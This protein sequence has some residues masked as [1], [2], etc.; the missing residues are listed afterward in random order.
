MKTLIS[1]EEIKSTTLNENVDD[2][3]I[4]DT[5][6][7]VQ[8]L[9]L[10]QLIGST[11]LNTLLNGIDETGAFTLN[12]DYYNLV[13]NYIQ[14]YLK[15]QVQAS[16][17]IPL[18]YKLRNAGLVTN[19]DNNFST[20]SYKDAKAVEQYM[21]DEAS[22]FANLLTK[23]LYENIDKFPEYKTCG[24]VN[25]NKSTDTIIYFGK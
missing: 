18:N 19:T 3:F 15:K 13:V 16:L 21:T 20:V 10:Q 1:I 17:I 9:K 25:S 7:T 8:T 11:L 14:P 12:D 4:L 23:Y 2:K 22:A 6:I 5:I 24:L